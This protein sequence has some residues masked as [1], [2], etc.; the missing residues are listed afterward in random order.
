MYLGNI[1]RRATGLVIA[2]TTLA[3]M[4][5]AL[6]A[7]KW[8]QS[9]YDAAHSG[10]NA[11]ETVLSPSNVSQ[12]QLRW[13]S[14]A[15]TNGVTQFVLDKR[16]IYAQ[17]QGSN[18]PNLS[19][20]NARTGATL[21]TIN[22]G[23]D[24]VF[25]S[26]SIAVAGS[27]IVAGCGFTDASGYGYGGIC[28][29]QK[30]NGAQ[31]W[32]FSNPCNC[33]PEAGVI[34]P[35]AYDKG[36]VYF[37]YGNGGAGAAEYVVALDASTGGQLW[38]SGTGGPNSLGGATIAVGNGYVY[39]SCNEH[40][41]PG[42]CAL[43]Q[44][45]GTPV[46]SAA[47]GTSTELG[48]GAGKGA[49]YVSDVLDGYY[50]ALNG[51]TG[52]QLWSYAC[53]SCGAGFPPSVAGNVMY[54]PGYRGEIY[55]LNAKRGTVLWSENVSD[56]S[57]ISIANG[58]LYLDEGGANQP[59]VAAFDAGS[60]SLLWSSAEPGSTL[61]PPPIVSEG[62]LYIANAGCGSICAYTLPGGRKKK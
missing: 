57:S 62:R 46:W 7:Q 1:W 22:T 48:L 40:G 39:L 18:T 26:G 36:V 27:I 2:A 4:P 50:F 54:A 49:V 52:A 10:Y 47:V 41:S 35:L 45:D 24:G 59:A 32:Q 12:L 3:V 31:V 8:L 44:T 15:P 42:V 56:N 6:A 55:V 9:Y 29:Y 25:L 5:P 58:V 13:G 20:I 28:G 43:D 11:H 61:S 60:G 51:T 33:A 14:S 17:G 30:P 23:N 37:G 53:E 19:A 21:Y 38:T 16:T 34:A